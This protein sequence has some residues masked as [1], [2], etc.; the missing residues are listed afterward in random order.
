MMPRVIT[1]A[2][3]RRALAAYTALYI[4]FLYVPVLLIPLFSFN[5]SMIMTFPLSGF[6]TQWYRQLGAQQELLAA[7][8]NSLYVGII[9]ALVATA[10]GTLAA[11][12]LTRYRF[13]GRRAINSTVM[14]PL[15]LP[16]III[17]VALLVLF[18]SVGIDLSLL[19]VIAAHVLLTIPFAV[20]IMTAAFGR[21]DDSL[22]EAAID[23]GESPWGAFRRVTL[24]VVRP[25]II[26]SLLMTF[27]VSFDEFLIA[28]FLT[29][30]SP[31]LP[32]YIWAQIRFPEKLPIVLALGSLLLLASFILMLT[33][34]IFR[35][36]AQTL[37][38]APSQET[39]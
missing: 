25:G 27:T 38:G 17:A 24:P 2:L 8:G 6:T 33:A 13:F 20:A 14:V 9:T 30:S 7:L 19:T 35:R 31:T 28:F 18:L 22:E 29:G 39:T 37:A 15:V 11:R 10:L 3:S 23:L 34:E 4:L 21:F 1:H 16:D 12:A 32:V 36:R 5:D 26:S